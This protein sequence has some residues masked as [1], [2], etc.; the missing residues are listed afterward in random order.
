MILLQ[1]S[2]DM[3]FR[4][5][6]LD[7]VGKYKP[8]KWGEVKHEMELPACVSGSTMKRLGEEKILPHR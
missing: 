7:K 1:V 4:E 8:S 3:M 5:V 2:T 6:T